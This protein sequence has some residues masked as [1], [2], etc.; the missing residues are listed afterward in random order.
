MHVSLAQVAV[1]AVLLIGGALAGVELAQWCAPNAAWAG[2][3]GFM[4]LP[5]SFAASI[6]LWQG[7]VILKALWHLFRWLVTRQKPAFARE[8]LSDAEGEAHAR[9]VLRRSAWVMLPAPP[10]VCGLAGV[11][12]GLGAAS[13][14]TTVAI[15][16]GVGCG[17]ALLLWGLAQKDLLAFGWDDGP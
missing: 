7:L 11:L 2:F 6:T 4:M 15:F 12:V 17:Y 9:A 5:L 3:P 1:V 10:A 16:F 14:V 8:G 13:F